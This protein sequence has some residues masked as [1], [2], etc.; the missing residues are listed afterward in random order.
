[1]LSISLGDESTRDSDLHVMQFE[2]FC[3]ENPRSLE[4]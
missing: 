3:S 1:M 2:T 4:C